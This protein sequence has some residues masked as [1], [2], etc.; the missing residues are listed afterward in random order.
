MALG[1]VGLLERY[2]D[3][4]ALKVIVTHGM[5][6]AELA[7]EVGHF[8]AL[9]DNELV[10]LYEAA[11]LHDV[12]V[13]GIQAP[14]IGIHGA[15]PYIM[16][17]IIGYE[18]LMKEGLPR[19]ALVCERHIGVGLTID[20]IDSQGLPLPRRNMSPQSVCEEIICF[21]DLFY[22]K[23][24]G[25]LEQRK[26]VAQVRNKLIGFGEHKV[27]IFDGWLRRFRTGGSI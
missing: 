18:I 19:H 20:D 23:K 13:C 6:V 22:S 25:K 14:H 9:P 8:L 27:L 7:L 15:A 4:E 10:F 26:S 1:S 24:P 17:G 2:F 5:V 16:H 11:M 3:R 12:G 21:A